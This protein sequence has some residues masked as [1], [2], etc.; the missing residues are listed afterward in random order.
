MKLRWVPYAAVS[1]YFHMKRIKGRENNGDWWLSLSNCVLVA[2]LR[3]SPVM[4]SE[5]AENLQH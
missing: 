3:D 2:W 1:G 5:L 4:Q